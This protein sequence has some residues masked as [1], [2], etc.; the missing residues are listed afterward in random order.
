M[1]CPRDKSDQDIALCPSARSKFPTITVGHP[2][3]SYLVSSLSL[4]SLWSLG[5]VCF[6]PEFLQLVLPAAQP[7]LLT[8]IALALPFSCAWFKATYPWGLRL[9][10]PLDCVFPISSYM[11]C[12]FPYFHIF[13]IYLLLDKCILIN[14]CSCARIYNLSEAHDGYIYQCLPAP[15]TEPSILTRV[16][17]VN[18]VLTSPPVQG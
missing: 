1:F 2:L 10:T 11:T 14:L 15:S 3:S 5:S 9:H 8:S 16:R 12:I 17:T 4:W 13:Y 7:S 6:C 18:A